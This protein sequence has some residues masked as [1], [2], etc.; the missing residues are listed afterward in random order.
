VTLQLDI[1]PQ[2]GQDPDTPKKKSKTREATRKEA[3]RPDAHMVG[4]RQSPGTPDGINLDVTASDR[5]VG[6]PRAELTILLS[7]MAHVMRA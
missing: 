4:S 3:A 1:K 2:H 5:K 6:L 7:Y